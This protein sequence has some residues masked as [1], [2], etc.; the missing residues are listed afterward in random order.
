MSTLSSLPSLK[1]L[2]LLYP[3]CPPLKVY[4]YFILL[5]P[6]LKAYGYFILLTLPYFLME[7]LGG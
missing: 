2:C 6:P 4:V 3:P 7:K 1:S 5:A